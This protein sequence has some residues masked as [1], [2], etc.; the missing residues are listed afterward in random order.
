M[1]SSGSRLPT[2]AFSTSVRIRSARS[3]SSA[4]PVI[5]P[6]AVAIAARDLV[7]RA[8]RGPRRFGAP[9][10]RGAATSHASLAEQRRA[11][12]GARSSSM[13]WRV[14][15]R[16]AAAGP[17]EREEPAVGVLG[18]ADA[19]DRSRAP[20]RANGR[21]RG[22][23]WPACAAP[24]R[25]AAAVPAFRGAL[26]D[27]LAERD[28]REQHDPDRERARGRERAAAASRTMSTTV[29]S[30]EPA[31]RAAAQSSRRHLRPAPAT[32]R[33][34]PRARRRPRL[35]STAPAHGG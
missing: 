2:M 8:S 3:R 7:A 30:G 26:A 14:A 25:S 11:R 18:V 15:S 1:S 12:S 16:A 5:A 29:A 27:E 6:P 4:S 24:P 31:E 17:Q 34:R 20:S 28:R 13:P 19:E 23:A 9:G 10:G 22:P 21:R 33:G 32:R 35:S